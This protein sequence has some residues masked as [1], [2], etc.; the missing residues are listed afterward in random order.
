MAP[1]VVV[2]RS[3]HCIII[4]TY[5]NELN[6][7]SNFDKTASLPSVALYL[8]GIHCTYVGIAVVVKFS[9]C[10]LVPGHSNI[11]HFKLPLV[12]IYYF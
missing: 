9:D 11:V 6:A 3:F 10:L 5:I 8:V 4:K 1:S 12:S 2:V 7:F